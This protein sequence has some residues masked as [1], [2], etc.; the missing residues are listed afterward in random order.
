MQDAIKDNTTKDNT[1]KD[2]AK[3][4]VI[5]RY[6]HELFNQGRIELIDELLDPD[7]VNHSPGSPE[8]DRGREG[9]REVVQLLRRAFPDLR[10]TIEDLV[11]GTDAVAVRTMMSG[12]HEGEFFGLPPTGR[13]FAVSQMTIEHF[14]GDRIVA[15]HR[16]TDIDALMRQLASG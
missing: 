7:Y 9:V 8:Q 11:I 12:T 10:Y 3:R 15:H 6:Y 4:R 14:R 1:T 2:G 16:V 5:E 13:R